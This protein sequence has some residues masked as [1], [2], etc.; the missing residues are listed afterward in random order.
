MSKPIEFIYV[1]ENNQ[2]GPKQASGFDVN[3]ERAAR[4]AEYIG[5]KVRMFTE[6]K[7]W[8][9]DSTP[10]H[11]NLV[12]ARHQRRGD[13]GYTRTI[14]AMFGSESKWLAVDHDLRRTYLDPGTVIAW[15]ELPDDPEVR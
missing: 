7:P 15:R 4:F 2:D 14:V 6:E 13:G 10:N 12:L 1:I 3:P 5:G 11:G 9:T 8:H